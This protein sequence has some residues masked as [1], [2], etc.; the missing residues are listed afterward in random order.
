MHLYFLR[1]I[2]GRIGQSTGTCV[3]NFFFFNLEIISESQEVAKIDRTVLAPCNDISYNHSTLA[4]SGNEHRG[5]LFAKWQTLFGAQQFLHVL[6]VWKFLWHFISCVDACEHQWGDFSGLKV[7]CQNVLQMVCRE[8]CVC[9]LCPWGVVEQT[10][11]VVSGTQ[12]GW[13]VC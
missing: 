3:L 13:S 6:F 10:R 7:Y 1:I 4:K 8:R 2:S 5:T 11:E 12:K 9:R